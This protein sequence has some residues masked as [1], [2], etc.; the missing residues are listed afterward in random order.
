MAERGFYI[1][2]DIAAAMAATKKPSAPEALYHQP[3]VPQCDAA[4]AR[5]RTA[6]DYYVSFL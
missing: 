1:K 6:I 4:I 3:P 2:D 5:D